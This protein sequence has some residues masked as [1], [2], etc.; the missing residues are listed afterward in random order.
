MSFNPRFAT[1]ETYLRW[2][3]HP[4]PTAK[5]VRTGW[6]D[7]TWL[8]QEATDEIKYT[9][10]TDPDGYDH[11]Y[12]GATV[13][14]VQNA[15][16]KAEIIR[17]EKEGRLTS[18]P[19]ESSKP[20]ETYW[21]LGYADKVSIW[22]A[23]AVGFQYRI[24][25]YYENTMQSLDHYAG[26]LQ[27]RGYTLGTMVLPWDGG[28]RQ[29]GTGRSVRELLQ[30]KGFKVRVLSQ[31]RVDLGITAVRTIFHQC[32][33]DAEKCQTGL[34]HL[35]KYQWGSPNANGEM[36]R[37]PLHDDA[38]HAADAFRTLAMHI[39]IPEE[40]PEKPKHIAQPPR[41]SGAY[42]PFG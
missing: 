11:V 31:N 25:E 41:H 24:I 13:S 2:V 6:E 5:V 33:F 20:V 18:V 36:K 27:S 1:D 3:V 16:Y 35:R 39:R 17:A 21:D 37:E 29:L 40:A 34:E 19:Y 10:A 7:N 9:R 4:P 28:A 23:Q 26:I 38:S 42:T 30:A 32:W 12:G 15:I 8:S 22:F 14:T